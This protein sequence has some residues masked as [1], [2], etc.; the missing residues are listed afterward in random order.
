MPY[1]MPDKERKAKL[2]AQLKK[3][4]EAITPLNPEKVILFGS[5]NHGDLNSR[6]DIDLL[7]VWNTGLPFLERT[8]VFYDAIQPDF[9]MDI[10]V[11]TPEEI[12]ELRDINPL[13]RKAFKEG[14]V[15]Y[16]KGT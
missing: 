13:I 14:R 1:S 3:A 10:L 6:S 9:A 4:I 7:V 16:E 11:Y 5:F 15:I 8:Q 2:S 12:G